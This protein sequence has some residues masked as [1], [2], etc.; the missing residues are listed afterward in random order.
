MFCSSSSKLCCATNIAPSFVVVSDSPTA[1][2][3]AWHLWKSDT[4]RV[5]L[6]ADS[7][8]NAGTAASSLPP[9]SSGRR[10]TLVLSSSGTWPH[11]ESYWSRW[12]SWRTRRAWPDCGL[13]H[14]HRLHSRQ[15]QYLSFVYWI[16]YYLSGLRPERGCHSHL[17]RYYGDST[18]DPPSFADWR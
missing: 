8:G 9:T 12:S 2:S 3:F 6:S 1:T 11:S 7:H 10:G 4:A 5:D 15:Y 16:D 14:H 18:D 13:P 17:A